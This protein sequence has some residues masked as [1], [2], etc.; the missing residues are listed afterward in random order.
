MT[1]PFSD[2]LM[3]PTAVE[4]VLKLLASSQKTTPEKLL[5]RLVRDEV[6]RTRADLD[7]YIGNRL[8]EFPGVEGGA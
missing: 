3:I 4:V 2:P 1:T 6:K 5:G 8:K 7:D